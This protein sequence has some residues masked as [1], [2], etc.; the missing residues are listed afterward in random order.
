MLV[1]VPADLHHDPD[2]L[3]AAAALAAA[4]AADLERLPTVDPDGMLPGEIVDEHEELPVTVGRATQE[5][6]RL[7]DEL[8]Q[9]AMRSRA[10]E[11]AA[12][13]RFDGAV[14]LDPGNRP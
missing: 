11:G 7:A 4:L 10:A 3:D 2:G 14:V 13:T 12:V 9:A 6:A 8:R 1:D 5:I